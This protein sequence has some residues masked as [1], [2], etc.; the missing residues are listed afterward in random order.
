MALGEPGEPRQQVLAPERGPRHQVLLLDGAHDGAA[1][2]GADRVARRRHDREGGLQVHQ[3]RRADHG[4]DRQP[5]AEPLAVDHDVRAQALG[6][7]SMEEAGAPH[8]HLHLVHHDE[9][10]VGAATLLQ[11]LEEAGGRHDE[12]AV[13]LYRLDE[14]GGDLVRLQLALEAPVEVVEGALD[15][16]GRELGAIRVGI[17]QPREA[18]AHGRVALGAVAGDRHRRGAAAVIRADEGE[19]AAAR[20]RRL[21][22]AHDGVVGVRA[23]MAEPDPA[24]A[25]AGQARQQVLGQ[26]DSVPDRA[27]SEADRPHVAHGLAHRLGQRRVAV[28]QARRAPRCAE[29]EHAPSAFLDHVGALAPHGGRREEADP[30][31]VGDGARVAGQQVVG[32]GAIPASIVAV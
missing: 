22:Q 11:S 16:I 9:D 26:P 30:L 12:A 6:L 3:L 31:D 7:E 17:D 24:L 19:D 13:R 20:R 27:R 28:A 18:V 10:S 14:D 21:Q 15:Q 5:A 8:S 23:G 25:I 32:H 29:V 2:G 1:G 4:R